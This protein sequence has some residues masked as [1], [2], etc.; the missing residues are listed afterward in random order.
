QI[1]GVLNLTDK[2]NHRTFDNFEINVLSSIISH[3]TEIYKNYSYKRK[4]EKRKKLEEELK[5]ASEIQRRN[6][7][8]I[9]KHI[10]DISISILYE[11][12]RVVGGDFFDYYRIRDD[13][14]GFLIA[15]V[16]GKGIPAAL[17]T[18]SVKN[19]LRMEQKI[20]S[21]PADLFLKA[22]RSII[23]ESE[24]GMFTT[25][26]YA[27]IYQYEKRILFSSAGHNDQ[28]LVKRNGN[29]VRLKTA[30]KPLG[31]FEE[32]AFEQKEVF[33]ESGDILVLFTDGVGESLGGSD[34]DIE[35]GFFKLADIILNFIDD[36]EELIL[37]R[38]RNEIRS[39]ARDLDLM[40]DLT[41]LLLR[42]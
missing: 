41:L 17:Y 40:D 2:K 16:A 34:L 19:I 1:V 27:L 20:C 23:L 8:K 26:F 4:E 37:N 36:S 3:V 6:L 11:P 15:D 9:P 10:G 32:I 21:T 29:V 33:Y 39:V 24:M 14:A 5:I 38:I 31:I 28:M 30:G 18:G 35:K 13:I 42:L 22:N 12:A 25:A 7:T